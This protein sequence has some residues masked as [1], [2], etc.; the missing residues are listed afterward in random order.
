MKI[1]LISH[2]LPPSGAGQA[3]IIYRMFETLKADSYC[4]ISP[5]SHDE[6]NP[7][8]GNTR[9]LTGKYYHLPPA[10][11]LKGGHRFGLRYVRD[12][13]NLLIAIRQNAR[14]VTEIVSREGSGAIVACTGDVTHLPAAYLASRRTGIPFHAYVFDHYS[15]REWYD[16]TAAFWA[17]RIESFLMKRAATVIT[18]NEILRD[19]LH[20][21]FGVEPVVIHNSLDI[22]SYEAN[23]QPPSSARDGEIKIV[24]T[25]EIYDAHYDA[26]RNLVAALKVLGRPEIKLHIYS[27]RPAAELNALGIDGPVVH[28]P[29]QLASE[30]PRIQMDADL[31]FLPLAF[32]SPYPELVRTSSTTKMG[33]YLAA[34]RPVLVHAPKDSFVNWY[35]RKHSCGVVVDENDPAHLAGAI[36]KTLANPELRQRMVAAAWECAQKEFSLSASRAAFARLVSGEELQRT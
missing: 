25:G 31:L 2:K 5:E 32:D 16:S 12:S 27:S 26:F 8:V 33:E 36:E 14:R 20:D 19:D 9:K 6:E 23:G 22:S 34:R 7:S 10:S 4:L 28:H 21:R 18:P 1:A 35:F 17:R 30:M 11:R 24:Y 3:V 15:Y 13:I 29:E